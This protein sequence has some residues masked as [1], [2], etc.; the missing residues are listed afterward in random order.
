LD[1]VEDE[2]M[3]DVPGQAGP[4]GGGRRKLGGSVVS[5]P[6]PEAQF[7][8]QAITTGEHGGSE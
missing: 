6:K 7:L 2:A 5:L 4:L 1:D 8:R 3:N